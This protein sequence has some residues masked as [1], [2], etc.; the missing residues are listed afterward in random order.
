MR[1]IPR[2]IK[3]LKWHRWFAW[4]PVTLIS[5]K[6]DSV[7]VPQQRAWLEIVERRLNVPRSSFEKKWTYRVARKK[8]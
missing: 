7:E 6:F 2:K 3:H 4:R 5:E 1:W 8:D